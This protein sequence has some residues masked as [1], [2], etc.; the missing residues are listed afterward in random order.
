MCE[1]PSVTRRV[2]IKKLPLPGDSQSFKVVG[3]WLTIPELETYP[4]FVEEQRK[5]MAFSAWFF[6]H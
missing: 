1:G 3:I 4:C 6:C 2:G 5:P